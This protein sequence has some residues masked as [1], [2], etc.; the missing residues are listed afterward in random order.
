MAP[1]PGS[2]PSE[3][4][5]PSVGDRWPTVSTAPPRR[6][7]HRRPAATIRQGSHGDHFRAP[8]HG[9]VQGEIQADRALLG[10]GGGARARGDSRHAEIV[11]ELVAEDSLGSGND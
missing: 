3:Q 4:H 2:H 5:H 11:A 10:G 9:I 8:R 6:R 7:H 1:G